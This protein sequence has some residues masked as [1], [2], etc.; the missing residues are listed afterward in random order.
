MEIYEFNIRVESQRFYNEENNFGVFGFSTDTIK[1]IPHLEFQD[2]S[3]FDDFDNGMSNDVGKRATGTIVGKVQMLEVGE[4]Y[5]F[6]GTM[7]YSKKFESYNFKP[8]S[9]TSKI[10]ATLDEQENFLK[11]VSTSREAKLLLDEYPNVIDLII[12]GE[13]IDLSNIKGIGEVTLDKIKNK[14]LDNYIIM[15]LLSFLSPYGI[16]FNQIKKIATDSDNP[17]LI[18][19][20]IEKN[21]YILTRINGLG[22]FKVDRIAL[23]LNKELAISELRAKEYI[24][25][26]LDD[27]ADREGHTLVNRNKIIAKA[28]K[29]VSKCVDI[30]KDILEEENKESTFLYVN[31]KIVGSL[32]H[33]RQELSILKHLN[34]LENSEN[35]F[36]DISDDLIYKII[37]ETEERQGFKFT[38]QQIDAIYGS[39]RS[40]VIIISGAAG[41]GKSTVLNG[42]YNILSRLKAT[43]YSEDNIC[44]EKVRKVV[45][46]PVINQCSLSAKAARR[47]IETTGRDATTI[48]RLLGFQNNGFEHNAL[49]KINTDIIISDEFSMN[50]VYISDS[51]FKAIPDG[52]KLIIVFDAFQLPAIGAGAVAYD[53]LQH[54]NFT[55]FSFTEV[56]R[57]AKKS[58]ILRD[59]NI[60]RVNKNPIKEFK[61]KVVSGELED[62]TYIFKKDRSDMRNFAIKSYL[63]AIEKFGEDNVTII[64]PRKTVVLNSSGEINKILQ[65]KLVA[66]VEG[67]YINYGDKEFRVG[68]KIIQKVNNYEYDVV[69]GESGRVSSIYE[70]VNS[71]GN[72]SK[73]MKND[74]GLDILG[75]DKTKIKLI[76]YEIS[77][78][79]QLEL[80]YAGTVHSWQGSQVD[81]VIG[82]IDSSHYIMLD[83]TLLYTLMTRASKRC[84]LITDTKSFKQCVQNNKTTIRETFLSRFL[85]GELEYEK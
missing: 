84:L 42:I 36:S 34:R 6:K 56:H 69:N 24:I 8:I 49:N 18:R 48:H 23:K 30:I 27:F 41:C 78:V 58:G 4:E 67:E 75:V 79:G 83:S 2:K 1:E 74:Y 39:V 44:K 37:I 35:R 71:Q 82:I 14:V 81:V 17:S 33:Y 40:N 12:N 77:E 73:V 45:R 3:V 26:I 62:M 51:L 15:D 7:E 31:E 20:E 47:M 13:Q 21:P 11:S 61:S 52:S 22:F 68:D 57:Q 65:N 80:F 53:L 5:L 60:I 32:K 55:K 85:K 76:E 38:Q 66:K 9:C 46:N 59:A 43:Y 54:S 64:V 10:P 63:S 16:T 29:D 28:R 72:K 50:N 25:Y 19:Q 70:N